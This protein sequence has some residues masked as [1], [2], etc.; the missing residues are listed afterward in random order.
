M[1]VPIWLIVPVII[2]L[3]LII[4]F[5]TMNQIYVLSWVKDNF[6]YFFLIAILLFSAF[7]LTKVYQKYDLDLSSLEGAKHAG[8]IYLGWLGNAIRNMGR[9][10]GYAVQQDWI[11]V[12]NTTINNLTGK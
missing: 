12:N 7:S 8:K 10:T 3:V 6:F 5:R 2:T 11:N 4:L 1:A 9:I